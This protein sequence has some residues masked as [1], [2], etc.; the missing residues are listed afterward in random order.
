MWLCANKTL[1]TKKG[2]WL[3]WPLVHNLLTPELGTHIEY[4]IKNRQ[5]K[6]VYNILI[7]IWQISQNSA[8]QIPSAKSLSSHIL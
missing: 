5:S 7:K 3:D 1:F 2:S 4:A 8:F 6:I